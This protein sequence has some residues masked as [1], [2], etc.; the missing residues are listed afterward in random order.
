MSASAAEAS[1]SVLHELAIQIAERTGL[2]GLT[3]SHE[4]LQRALTLSRVAD[5]GDL[6]R[7]LREGRLDWDSL[8]D[9]LT[10]RETYFFRHPDQFEELRRRVLPTLHGVLRDHSKLRVWSAGC[11]SGEEAYS[12]A[13]VFER[14][15]L[16]D[17]AQIIAT[18]ISPS[19]LERGRVGHYREWSMRSLQSELRARYFRSEGSGYNILENLREQIIWRQL[20]LADPVYPSLESNIGHLPLIFCRNVLMFFDAKTIAQVATRLWASLVPGGWLFL[21]PSDPNVSAYADFEVHVTPAGLVYRRPSSSYPR[22]RSSL[23]PPLPVAT[24]SHLSAPLHESGEHLVQ[25]VAA[26]T[27]PDNIRST[28]NSQSPEAALSL[29]EAALQRS[30]T[31]LELHHLHGLLLWELQRHSEAAAAMRRVLYLDP[32]NAIAHFGLANLLERQSALAAARRSY[33]NV[34]DVCD[35]LPPDAPLPLGE[36]ICV[37]GLH[38][39]AAEGLV[40]L[41]VLE[42]GSL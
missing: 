36:G 17:R 3:L 33:Q 42:M 24:P 23:A 37:S 34:L 12:L 2:T 22:T 14:E 32:D 10:V 6:E 21:G 7:S 18:D 4:N 28:W 15:G 41:K 27:L 19:A 29:C 35:K 13:I 5:P 8:I 11:A 30:E 20:N 38:A 39:A 40:R 1:P 16:G 31:S 26:S 25:P 9:A